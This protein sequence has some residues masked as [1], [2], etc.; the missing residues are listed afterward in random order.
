MTLVLDGKTLC[1]LECILG[2]YFNPL[3]TFMNK[4]DWYNVCSNMH[5]TD[6]TFFPLPV[7]LAVEKETVYEGDE[8]LLVD[9]NNNQ[10]A[11][12]NVSEI[13]IPDIDFECLSAYGTTDDNHPYVLYKNNHR[14]MVYVS[15][16]LTKLNDIMYEDYHN[17]RLKPNEV[18]QML[19]EKGWGEI[20]GFQTRN[21]MHRAHFELTKYALNQM[22]VDEPKLL[23]NPVVGETQVNDINYK[24]RVNCYKS[25]LNRYDDNQVILA[26]LP[27]AMRMAGPREAC[28][29][30]LIR[31]N[32]GCTHF[33]V[34][35][36]H[37][38]PSYKT[39][40]G[41]DFYG[42]YDAQNLL[43][44]HAE[45]INIVPITSKMIVYNET[46]HI[47]QPIDE[48]DEGDNV[49]KLSGTQVR[50]KLRNNEDI[51]EWFSYPDIVKILRS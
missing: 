51:P 38:G 13:F 6:G 47:Y 5:L 40:E 21:P 45:E 34:G 30:A 37:A 18:K 27:L 33:I 48:V 43:F 50:E 15:G 31:K 44:K 14:N 8:L 20:V 46:K 26:L 35:R 10:L 28:L 32:Y 9:K 17:L 29:H 16:E 39:K 1:D 4:N 23:L 24:T 41:N 3:K 12:L 36:D 19:N 25:M 11:K 49:L 7:T 42:P 2:G 22:N